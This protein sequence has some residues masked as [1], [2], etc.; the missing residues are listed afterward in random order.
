MMSFEELQRILG[1]EWDRLP[2][3]DKTPYRDRAIERRLQHE[4]MGA[5]IAL[6]QVRLHKTKKRVGKQVRF[7]GAV[8]LRGYSVRKSSVRSQGNVRWFVVT[9]P[10][11]L[12]GP[13]TETR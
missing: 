6:T 4:T 2:E 1:E 3:A 7:D 11:C 9:R 13:H 12:N 10:A 5:A 8:P